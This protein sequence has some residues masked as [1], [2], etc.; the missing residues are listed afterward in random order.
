LSA[1]K[2]KV[3]LLDLDLRKGTL[4]DELGAD[5]SKPGLSQYLSGAFSD[6]LDDMLEEVSFGDRK[7]DYMQSGPLPPNPAELLLSK[8][9]ENLVKVL[10][11]H[12]DYIIMDCPPFGLVADAAVI[13]RTTDLCVYVV[14]AGRYDRRQL[15][16]LERLYRQER[17][18][19]MALALNAVDYN[20]AGYYAYHHYGNYGYGYYGYGHYGKKE[21]EEEEENMDTNKDTTIETMVETAKEERDEA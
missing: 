2:K 9:F 18:G 17:L 12:Y 4:S 11:E 16:E 21:K 1:T 14:R 15:P 5:R 13:S 10:R 19:N 20:Y 3:I 6:L 8:R 7:L